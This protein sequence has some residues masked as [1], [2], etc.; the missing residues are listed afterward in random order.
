MLNKTML[1]LMFTGIAAASA[2]QAARNELPKANLPA[3]TA[4]RSPQTDVLIHNK[5]LNDP[6]S[7]RVGAEDP[8]LI[9][10]SFTNYDCIDCKQVD[11]HLEKLLNAYPRIAV[12]YKLLSWGPASSTAVTR[13]A[14][15]VWIEQPDKFHVF[16]H[17]L[18]SYKGM[19]D[20][21]RIYS[22]YSAAGM[23]L[24]TFRP[25]T[26]H[27]IDVNKEFLKVMHLPGTP[28]TLIG[29]KVLLGAVTYDALEE[30][31]KAAL[32]ETKDGKRLAVTKKKTFR[33]G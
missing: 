19:A 24:S 32:A 20:D 7:P 21:V 23:K 29:D 22:A 31:V 5:L 9:V 2:S 14:L 10:V 18:M 28:A 16:H 17:A 27:I 26:Q 3:G 33:T 1:L 15:S 12:T 11:R 13:R 25:D 30:A 4:H 8:D 6:L